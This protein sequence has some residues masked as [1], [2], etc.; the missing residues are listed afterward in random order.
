MIIVATIKTLTNASPQAAPLPISYI[1]ATD[2]LVSPNLPRWRAERLPPVLSLPR[3]HRL[4]WHE[5]I[6]E[7]QVLILSLDVLVWTQI[8]LQMFPFK[9]CHAQVTG[10]SATLSNQALYYLLKLTNVSTSFSHWLTSQ[11]VSLTGY[12]RSASL[13]SNTL[14]H[15]FSK[16]FLECEIA[17]MNWFSFFISAT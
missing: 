15:F 2:P 5:C 16:C 6:N 3:A 9:R 10:T 12:L 17:Q 11:T 4:S 1:T 7:P 8:W 13:L 14:N